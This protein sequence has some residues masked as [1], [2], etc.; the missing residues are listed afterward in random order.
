M[1]KSCGNCRRRNSLTSRVHQ[2]SPRTRLLA[3]NRMML[4]QRRCRLVPSSKANASG[5][6]KGVCVAQ[7]K[8]LGIYT[9]RLPSTLWP[10]SLSRENES[11]PHE[12]RHDSVA[13]TPWP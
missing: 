6:A 7:R 5:L 11:C 1:R 12:L 10:Q 2:N 9:R 4:H 3:S 13:R 8:D